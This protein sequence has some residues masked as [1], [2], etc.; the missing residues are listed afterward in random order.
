MVDLFVETHD[1]LLLCFCSRMVEQS[2]LRED[3][4]SCPLPQVHLFAF[5][6]FPLIQRFLFSE[7]R[8]S[9]GSPGCSC[10]EPRFLVSGSGEDE[11]GHAV[12]AAYEFY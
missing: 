2:A 10:M 6:P 9:T 1:A 7:E 8:G 12:V 4:L 5:P 3:A 11:E